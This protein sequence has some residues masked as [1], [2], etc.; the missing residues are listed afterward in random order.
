MTR[1][2]EIADVRQGLAMAGR[3]AGAQRGDWR[4]RVVDSADILDDQLS[5]RELREVGLRQGV[6]T[7]AH[8][9]EPFD[10]VVAARARAAKVALVPPGVHRTVAAVTLLVVRTPDPGMGLAHYLWY[11]LT[12]TLGR[13]EVAARFTATSLPSLSAGALGEVPVVVPPA[14]ELPRIADLAEA[15]AASRRAALEAVR[16]RHDIVRDSVIADIATTGRER[17]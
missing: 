13:A 15:A 11:Y 1:L 7:A 6:R 3:G 12:S 16:I 4:V 14:P 5:M 2:M 10:L 17:S 9:L 8:L